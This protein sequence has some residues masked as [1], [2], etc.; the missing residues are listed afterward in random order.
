VEPQSRVD[1]I[2]QRY[3]DGDLSEAEMERMLEREIDKG[4]YDSIDRELGRERR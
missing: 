1:R 2:K 4:E 3:A